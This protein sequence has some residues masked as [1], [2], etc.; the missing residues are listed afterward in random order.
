MFQIED[1]IPVVDN[2]TERHTRKVGANI[3]SALEALKVGQSFHISNED[4]V[5]VSVRAR[6]ATYS[7]SVQYTKRFVCNSTEQGVRVHRVE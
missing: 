4:Y 2:R 1:G 3:R 5:R 7:R 6:V